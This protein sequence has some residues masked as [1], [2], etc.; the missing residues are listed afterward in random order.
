MY[1]YIIKEKNMLNCMNKKENSMGWLT[2]GKVIFAFAIVAT[3]IIAACVIMITNGSQDSDAAKK[4]T[5][6]EFNYEVISEED[7]TVKTTQYDNSTKGHVTIP[8]TVEYEG[9]IYT[10]TCIGK[11]TFFHYYSIWGSQT[12]LVNSV[13]TSLTIPY[14]VK[15]I[16]KEAITKTN[17]E[18]LT[19]PDTVELIKKDAVKENN[20]LTT[21][22]ILGDNTKLEKNAFEL[23]E[24]VTKIT[25]PIGAKITDD[26]IKIDDLKNVETVTFAPGSTGR[27]IDYTTDGSGFKYTDTLWYKL[28]KKNEINIIFQEGISY[29]GSN[30]FYGCENIRSFSFPSYIESIGD[31]AFGGFRFFESDSVEISAIPINLEGRTFVGI[32]EKMVMLV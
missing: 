22:E 17:I 1:E 11:N 32:P 2:H 4:F 7:L 18:I 15:T 19:I 25:I 8:Q 10:V 14:T 21:I 23:D 3:L 30:M 24:S 9:K 26:M 5:V 13:I 16:D 12:R 20:K 31:L 29:I 28:N 6:A 27:G